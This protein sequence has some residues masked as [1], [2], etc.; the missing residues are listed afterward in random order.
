MCTAAGL[1][2]V[3]L[4]EAGKGLLV[5]AVGLGAL[6][7]SHS[8]VPSVAEELVR[9]FH[10]NPGR[11]CPSIFL[12]IVEQATPPRLFL[13]AIG[14]LLY[15]LVRFIEA[16]GLW[17]ERRWAAWF[18]VISSGIYIPIEAAKLTKAVTWSGMILLVGNLAIILFLALTLI[19][20]RQHNRTEQ[21]RNLS[22]QRGDDP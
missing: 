12:H 11:H 14:A 17:R 4:F 16:F 9:H 7:L 19:R 15:A 22:A 18:A 5:L 20:A 6:S 10:L 8:D 3:A 13:I 21:P 2:T 1:R